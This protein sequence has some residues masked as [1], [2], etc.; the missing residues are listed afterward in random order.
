MNT[1]TGDSWPTSAYVA[2]G[3]RLPAAATT[4]PRLLLPMTLVLRDGSQVAGTPLEIVRE[5]QSHA[6]GA[7]TLTVPRYIDWVVS[8]VRRFEEVDLEVGG[9]TDEERASS[10]LSEMIRVGLAARA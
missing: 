3:P 7:A 8:N 9:T 1:K 5:M 6:R 2:S 4:S 10:L